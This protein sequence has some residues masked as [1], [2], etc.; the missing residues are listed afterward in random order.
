MNWL[1]SIRQSW[2]HTRFF[3]FLERI[4]RTYRIEHFDSLLRPLL[5]TW[6]AC[7]R[8][9]G[10]VETGV[11]VLVEGVV[12]GSSASIMGVDEGEEDIVED[13]MAALA[14]R[15]V[16]VYFSMLL[17]SRTEHGPILL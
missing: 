2:A 10:D 15:S 1:Y 7:A 3:S 4:A 13:L 16:C 11:R 6:C 5:T 12:C 14:V 9:M 17:T 8:Q